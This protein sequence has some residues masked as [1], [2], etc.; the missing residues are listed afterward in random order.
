MQDAPT[1]TTSGACRGFRTHASVPRRVNLVEFA[2][3]QPVG[4]QEVTT[5]MIRNVPNQYHRGMLMQ[6]LNRLGFRGKYD[7]AYLPIDRYT[8][9]NVGYAFVNFD[10]T[11]DTQR[12]MKVMEGYV[13]TN[14]CRNKQKRLAQVSVAHIQGLEQNLAHCMGSAV[15]A[16]HS[17]WLRPWVRRAARTN[18]EGKDADRSC[19][20]EVPAAW[21]GD[22]QGECSQLEWQSQWQEMQ[23]PWCPESEVNC[24]AGASS[25]LVNGWGHAS[26]SPYEGTFP[27]YPTEFSA[28]LSE[29]Q[30]ALVFV[31]PVTHW[32]Q[33]PSEDFCSN[34]DVSEMSTSPGS[35]PSNSGLSEAS[36]GE[37][38][39]GSEP[40]G[41]IAVLS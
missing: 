7:F 25:F 23:T 13:F 1:W 8:Q 28:A 26:E 33:L 10:T 17:P 37:A 24:L 27:V 32:V 31:M 12:F 16:S 11:E 22:L 2:K 9:L 14:V 35:V 18:L 34:H 38:S 4:E 41:A 5:V 36:D 6:E 29:L 3:G 39:A 40:P 30:Y 15:F 19:T 20:L 21:P